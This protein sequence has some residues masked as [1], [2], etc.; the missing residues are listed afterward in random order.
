MA[1]LCVAGAMDPI[2]M[3]AVGAAI[4]IERLARRPHR[5]ARQIGAV[6][7]VVGLV[8]IARGLGRG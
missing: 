1:D 7:M 3:L 6:A 2:A 5:I 4:T 8:V